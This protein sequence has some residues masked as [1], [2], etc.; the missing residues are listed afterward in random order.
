MLDR[1]R[2]I[3][4]L[5]QASIPCIVWGEDAIR[6]FGCRVVVGRLFLIVPNPNFAASSLQ[7]SGEY[8]E[9]PDN[10]SYDEGLFAAAPRLVHREDHSLL[11]AL[12]R[13]SDWTHLPPL[14]LHPKPHFPSL[15]VLLASLLG[16]WLEQPYSAFSTRVATWLSY[17][18]SARADPALVPP[19]LE[20]DAG[21]PDHDAY[22]ALA[23]VI[24]PR[25]RQFHVDMIH[26]RVFMLAYPAY[27][28]FSAVASAVDERAG[29]SALIHDVPP[30]SAEEVGKGNMPGFWYA[31]L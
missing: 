17:V 15:D 9:A 7:A 8:E 31:I 20:C 25:L 30:P 23:R 14:V 2:P 11:V 1:Y 10:T 22:M 26:G 13:V 18:Y 27:M 21:A 4:T 28:H 3:D 24:P 19:P 29:D 12:L 16:T 5:R 6:Q